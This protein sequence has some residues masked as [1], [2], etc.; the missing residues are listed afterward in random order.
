M[1]AAQGIEAQ[2]IG[3]VAGALDIPEREIGLQARG[4]GAAVLEAKGAGGI[5][6]DAEQRFFGRQ[7][8]QHAGHVHGGEQ[9]MNGRR[10]GVEV[11]CNGDRHVVR[12]QCGDRRGL[13]FA[14]IIEGAGQQHGHRAGVGDGVDALLVEI[15]D[16]IDGEG[17][18]SAPPAWRRP[19]WR[20]AR[21]GA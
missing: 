2:R 19:D 16:V 3:K 7:A 11:G 6:G 5:G 21:H 20:V 17:A 1:T 10:A 9:G 12:A 14:Q 18:D 13:L 8:E 4:D 15:F